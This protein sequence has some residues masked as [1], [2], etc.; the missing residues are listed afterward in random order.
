MLFELPNTTRI[1]STPMKTRFRGFF[2]LMLLCLVL[3]ACQT[4]SN[5]AETDSAP[6]PTREMEKEYEYRLEAGDHLSL[7]F[8]FNEEL[9]DDV[10][11]APDGKASLMMVGS[12]TLAGSTVEELEETLTKLYDK[13]VAIPDITVSLTSVSTQKVYV[14]GEV[15]LP[16]VYEANGGLTLTQAIFMA[17]GYQSSG[18]ISSVVILRDTGGPVLEYYIVDVGE[19]LSTLAGFQDLRLRG[20]DIVFVPKSRVGSINQFLNLHLKG[21]KE[22]LGVF[23]FTATYE[24][25]DF[26]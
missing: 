18:K 3:P 23:N 15:T 11:V 9:N 16:G 13:H 24:L 19:D 21:L 17:G 20:R 8:L 22:I 10:L 5:F 14:G 4:T 25:R 1:F 7:K 6:I 2:F 26:D 12:V